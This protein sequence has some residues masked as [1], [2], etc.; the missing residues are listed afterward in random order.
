MGKRDPKGQYVSLGQTVTE[1]LAQNLPGW[2]AL[3]CQPARADAGFEFL[4]IPSVQTHPLPK[5]T[6]AFNGQTH[7]ETSEA[8]N[9]EY[10]EFGQVTIESELP[11]GQYESL[12]HTVQ[13]AG[14]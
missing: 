3:H 13:S 8:L 9:T 2:H 11:P 7:C 1:P 4:Y 10:V 14:V 12:L 6:D 5:T